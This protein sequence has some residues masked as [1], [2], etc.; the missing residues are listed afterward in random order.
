[1][2]KRSI[3]LYWLILIVPSLVIA[4]GGIV[5]L[6]GEGERLAQ[7][8]R[9]SARD[10]ARAIAETVQVTV[11]A[12]EHDL[13]AALMR[14][15]SQSPIDA[16]LDWKDANPLIRNVFV[17]KPKTGLLYPRN[18]DSATPEERRFIAR[19]QSLFSDSGRWFTDSAGGGEI[20]ES[21]LARRQRRDMPGE[22]EMQPQSMVMD[23]RSLRSGRRQL[24][25]LAQSKFKTDSEDHG[26]GT[27]SEPSSEGWIPWFSDNKLHII[28]WVRK[29]KDDVVYGVELELVTL[30]SQ[31]VVDFP[32][33]AAKGM[34]YALVDDGGR[35]IHQAGEPQVKPGEKSEV[36]VSL[37]PH[38]PHWQIAVYM[39]DR[40][41]LVGAGQGFVILSGLLLG[42]FLIAVVTGGTLLTRQAYRNWLDA[43]QKSSFVS[44]VSHELK[45]PLTS[46]RMYAELLDEDRIKDP[47][48]KKRYLQVIVSES[49][50]LGR[51]VNNVLDFSR[52]E[53][54]RM[55]YHL[56]EMDVSGFVRGIIELHRV[57]IQA[58]GMTLTEEIPEE[59]IPARA[60]RDALKQVLINII[61]NAIKYASDGGELT[62]TVEVRDGQCEINLMDRGPG[63][64]EGHRKRIFEKFHRVDDSL[65]TPRPGVGLGLPI[66]RRI[67]RDHGGDLIHRPRSGGGSC[68]IITVPLRRSGA[69]LIQ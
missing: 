24:Q 16:L 38:L 29:P 14:I 62:V 34:V 15:P 1:M 12:V 11:E 66:A 18:E 13:S 52:L 59:R 49:E 64:P 6:R 55:K 8:E 40:N 42:I 25:Q 53:Q 63:V 27:V 47:E 28:G 57:R 65:T 9:S 51:L 37:A 36:A 26:A 69:S 23:I 48:K 3:I 2:K 45:T 22:P 5:L 39:D 19:Y 43:Q 35:I 31:L 33:S 30:L 68:F 46:I 41:P 7:V 4:A 61:D 21:G 60:D 54:G 58:A 20:P 50:R 44:N 10:R 67:L 56:E 17:W 32:K